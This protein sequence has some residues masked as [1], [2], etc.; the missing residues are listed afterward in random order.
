MENLCRTEEAQIRLKGIMEGSI[1]S[2]GHR[3]FFDKKQREGN[4]ACSYSRLYRM[5]NTSF[6]GDDNDLDRSVITKLQ[7]IYNRHIGQV[8]SSSECTLT[9]CS[10]ILKTL[11]VNFIFSFFSLS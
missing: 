5:A 6:L 2:E 9:S 11:I 7:E 8:G 3:L 1:P 10:P 4:G